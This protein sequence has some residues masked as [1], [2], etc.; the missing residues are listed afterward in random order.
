VKERSTDTRSIASFIVA[1]TQLKPET[2]RCKTLG[3]V[4]TPTANFSGT[5]DVYQI[6]RKNE[7]D[8]LSSN[9]ILRKL[10]A[11]S[12]TFYNDV[13]FRS[14]DSTTMLKDAKGNPIPGTGPGVGAKRKYLNLDDYNVFGS[15]NYV[16]DYGLPAFNNTTNVKTTCSPDLKAVALA[17]APDCR[18]ASFTSFD[19]GA[20]YTGF[21]DLTLSAMLHSIL[22]KTTTTPFC[23]TYKV[24][25]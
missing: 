1:S 10:Y 4:F 7:I 6:S 8:R 20:T 22:T 14:P 23:T 15:M 24:V 11:E 19:M 13:V 25:P 9:D 2:S 3:L 12:N 16:R 5:L 17:E 18:V 21:K